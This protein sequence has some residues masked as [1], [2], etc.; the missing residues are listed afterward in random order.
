MT[1]GIREAVEA[2]FRQEYG[3]VVSVLI[4][5][6]G[7]FDLAEEAVQDALAE[8]LASWDRSGVP[9]N[10]AAWITTTARRR[11]IDKLRRSANLARKQEV[12]A[13]LLAAEQLDQAPEADSMI[14]DERLRLIFTCCHPALSLE[15]QVAL[16]LRT[17]GGL[18]TVEIAHCFLVSET[19][20]AQ[21]LVRAKRKIRDAGIPYRVPPDH[22]L[23][24]RMVAVLAVIYLIFNE[25]YAASAGSGLVRND[26]AEE[27][28]RLG[29]LVV[30]LMPNEP[31]AMGLLGLMYLHHSRRQARVGTDGRMVLLP[32]QNR[33]LWDRAHIRRGTALA[34]RALRQGRPGPYQL[35]AAIAAHHAAAAD[36][37]ETDWAGIVGLY[38]RLV[39]IAASPVILLNRAVAVAMA[40]G[41]EAGLAAIGSLAETL[42][43][44]HHYHSARADLLRRLGRN[45]E[46]AVAYRHALALVGNETERRYLRARLDEVS[47]GAG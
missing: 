25:G 3:K 20:M 33:E 13:G 29:E 4:R 47:G 30:A 11:A 9:R 12:L 23:P 32:D 38:D 15:A 10:P 37:G 22:Q 21:R 46:A 19:T 45:E 35:Q 44:Y 16:T 6:M 8:A 2:V 31:E 40:G 26:L 27:A 39:E 14:E 1:S 42:E 41:P 5:Q 36:R 18:S 34:A 28:I 17:L 24:D 43:G 7:D